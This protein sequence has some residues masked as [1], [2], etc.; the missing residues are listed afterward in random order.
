[1][2]PKDLRCFEKVVHVIARQEILR[3]FDG[4]HPEIGIFVFESIVG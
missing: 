2:E 4:V 1:M 3:Y